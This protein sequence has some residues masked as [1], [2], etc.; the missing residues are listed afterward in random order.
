MSQRLSFVG[1]CERG[2]VRQ[3]NKKGHLN[4]VRWIQSLYVCKKF[5]SNYFVFQ[6]STLLYKIIF[7]FNFKRL[8]KHPFWYS[9]LF[10]KAAIILVAQ[11][12]V[13]LS[14]EF[15]TIVNFAD[16]FCKSLTRVLLFCENQVVFHSKH[17]SEACPDSS[18]NLPHTILKNKEPVFF[19]FFFATNYSPLSFIWP[20]M[21]LTAALRRHINYP[22]EVQTIRNATDEELNYQLEIL[23]AS[24]KF[25]FKYILLIYRLKRA[26]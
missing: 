11:N 3:Q 6:V 25:V 13:C 18:S 20:K 8:T 24:V 16:A 15:S 22:E 12:G 5:M 7:I 1:Q 9:K 19:F 4:I 17:D 10:T 23:T 14:N 26:I 21:S 2:I